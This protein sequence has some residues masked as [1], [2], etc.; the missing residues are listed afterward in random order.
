[1]KFIILVSVM[2][3][4]VVAIKIVKLIGEYKM[5]KMDEKVRGILL[6]AANEYYQGVPFIIKHDITFNNLLECLARNKA[7]D[8]YKII[9]L[10]K[11]AD[12]AKEKPRMLAFLLG[13][14]QGKKEIL[15]TVFEQAQG[16]CV[17]A[18]EKFLPGDC[19]SGGYDH[20]LKMVWPYMDGLNSKPEFDDYEKSEFS[21]SDKELSFLDEGSY[22]ISDSCLY[23]RNSADAVEDMA[24]SVGVE[25]ANWRDPKKIDQCYEYLSYELGRAYEIKGWNEYAQKF[26]EF[27]EIE[28]LKPIAKI[29]PHSWR[30]KHMDR[31]IHL[32]LRSLFGPTYGLKAKYLVLYYTLSL[33][34][35][36]DHYAKKYKRRKPI[37]VF[38]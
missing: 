3:V 1:M 2:A 22:N 27:A 10:E 33:L 20:S 29:D 16:V 19:E 18:T 32:T 38:C 26:I 35:S 25:L 4:I 6:E 15:F 9:R 28:G 5:D 30:L 36:E 11:D 8:L 21:F 23:T 31:S 34:K 7:N 17:L 37:A 14:Q 13:G 24:W 12:S